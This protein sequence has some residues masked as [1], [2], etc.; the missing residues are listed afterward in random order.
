MTGDYIMKVYVVVCKTYDDAYVVG[1]YEDMDRANAVAATNVN[2]YLDDS[3][4][5]MESDCT[6]VSE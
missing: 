2:Y 1:V 6:D 5:V 4:L 3:E